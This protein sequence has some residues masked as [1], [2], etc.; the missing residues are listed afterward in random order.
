MLPENKEFNKKLILL[1]KSNP[2]YWT[3][4][5]LSDWATKVEDHPLTR[6]GVGDLIKRHWRKYAGEE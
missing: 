3:F 1:K 4:K 2:T 5:R 6:Q